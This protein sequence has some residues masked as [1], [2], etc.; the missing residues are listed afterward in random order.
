MTG[1]ERSALLPASGDAGREAADI[2]AAIFEGLPA[3]GHAAKSATLLI[4]D[5][6]PP[7]Q[8]LLQALLEPQGYMTL[9]SASG[10]DALALMLHVPVDLVLLDVDMPGM[11]GYAVARAIK[12]EAATCD[13]P[14][15]MVTALA[16]SAARLMGLE[17][18][19]EDFLTKPIDRAELWLRV[20]NLLRL[21]TS[22]DLLRNHAEL[23][24]QQVR[25]R[26][27]DLGRLRTAMDATA[28]AIFL[29]DRDTLRFVEV[30]ATACALLGYSRE[31]LLERGPV[32]LGT[33]TIEQVEKMFDA[34]IAGLGAG[35]PSEVS[36]RR[37]DG[38][39]LVV[40]VTRVAQ[41]F[42]DS[43]LIVAVVRDITDRKSSERRLYRLAHFDVLTGLPNRAHFHDALRLALAAGRDGSLQLSVLFIDLDHF[44][45]VNDTLGHAIGDE[46]LA[47]VSQRL[48]ACVGA[49]DTIGRLGGDEFAVLLASRQGASGTDGVVRRIRETLLRPFDLRGH[50]MVVT[51]SIGITSCPGDATDAETLLKYADIAMYRAKLGGRNCD[52]RFT[53][54]MHNDVLERLDLEIALR[55]AV[56]NGEFVVHYQPKV[57][58]ADGDISGLEA[59][60]RW[61]RPGYGMVQPGGFIPVLEECGL[62]PR[63]GMWVIGTVCEQVSQ[64][65]RSSIGRMPVA[66]NVTQRQ[67]IEG[68]LKHD[69]AAMLAR[70]GTPADLL[71]L[72]LTEGSLM[73]HTDRTMTA[74]SEL[75]AMG[76]QISVDDFGTGY[77]SLAYLRQFPLDKLKIDIAFIRDITTKP[78]DAAVTLAI[79]RLAHSLN[80][81]VIAEGV[82]TAAQV[83]FLKHHGCEQVQGYYF[84]RPLAPDALEAFVHA[85]R[86]THFV[87]VP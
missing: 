18:G 15:I 22:A 37:K 26:N 31:E 51:V 77:S 65:M 46:L 38:S 44:K 67:F 1:V 84:S 7:N 13:I 58:L 78:D 39:E 52:C 48:S 81:E 9:T 10:P 3:Q 14:I 53:P 5:D 69:I 43:W 2:C 45:N 6:R 83:E 41:R 27:E 85:H 20:R 36:L 19:A 25:T 87:P 66:V 11:D 54:Q 73:A 62:M 40:D 34:V 79:I 8:R 74:L 70:H 56:D 64:W 55:K 42:G 68:D 50:A 30:N 29:I 57:R 80:L 71:E 17:A 59:L 28:D 86:H 33:G 12:G 35:R 63:V 4:V 16:D 47:Q 61:Q 75:R 24:A 32:N 60:L 49:G 76:M 21:K 23:L 72:E 82:E